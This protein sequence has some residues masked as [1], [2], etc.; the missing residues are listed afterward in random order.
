MTA[1]FLSLYRSAALLLFAVLLSGSLP[2]SAQ[3]QPALK[4]SPESITLVP[5]ASDRFL[6]SLQVAGSGDASLDITTPPSVRAEVKVVR[7]PGGTA[8]Q[9]IVMLTAAADFDTEGTAILTARIGSQVFSAPLPVKLH[10]AATADSQLKVELSFEGESLMDGLDRPLL[11]RVSNLSDAPTEITVQP[12]LPPFLEAKAGPWQ[13]PQMVAGRSTIVVEIPIGTNTS[14]YA[15]ISGKHQVAVT[16]TAKRTSTPAW[17]GQ[18]VAATEL[19]VGVPGMSEVQGILQIPS[20]LLFPGFLLITAFTV[21]V[22]FRNQGLAATQGEKSGL[23][24]EWSSGLWLIAITLSIGMVWAYGPLCWLFGFGWRN[25]LYG[26]DLGDVLRV[27]GFSLVLGGILALVWRFIQDKRAANRA[28]SEFSEGLEPL[29]LVDRLIRR[30]MVSDLPFVTLPAPGNERLYQLGGLLTDG[31]TWATS[32]IICSIVD[33]TKQGF[34]RRELSTA[35]RSG[36]AVTLRAALV[37]ALQLGAIELKWMP[38][39]KIT[40][41]GQV[42]ATQ[43]ATTEGPAPIV[44]LG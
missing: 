23:A 30:N 25:I 19:T 24:V 14:K 40:G 31:K 34:D 39:P 8:R 29:D 18:S 11:A 42:E 27:W 32:K 6:V 1:T 26:F 10:Q 44:D 7:A 33:P 22:R 21:A 12:R 43:F 9:W 35:V 41:V 16:V 28:K 20:F 37:K 2:A 17:S 36:N 38:T 13:Q 4:P 5:G 15:L 3:N